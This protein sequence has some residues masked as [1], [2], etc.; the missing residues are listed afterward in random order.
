MASRRN[1]GVVVGLMV[2]LM[3][4]LG[5]LTGHVPRLFAGLIAIVAIGIIVGTRR[6][7]RTDAGH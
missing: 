7:F 6:G 3:G 4:A 2:A 1:V 5:L